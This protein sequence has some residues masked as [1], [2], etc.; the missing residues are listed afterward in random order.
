[1]SYEPGPWKWVRESSGE[2]VDLG[3]FK[4]LGFYDNPV[5]IASGR[6]IIISAGDGEYCPIVGLGDE[7]DG[8]WAAANARL[9]AAAPE[10]VEALEEM[11][12][13]MDDVRQGHYKPDSFTTSVH[14]AL[15]ARI[16]GEA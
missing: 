16:K 5:L 4:C 1:M 10:L 15:L 2:A 8:K 9:I 14:R 13:L 6:A 12:D 11:C 7:D 3:G